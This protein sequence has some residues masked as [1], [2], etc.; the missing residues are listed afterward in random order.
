MFGDAFWL[1][2]LKLAD[3][4]NTGG[5]YTIKPNGAGSG[6]ELVEV[7]S[8]IPR[9]PAATR[10][11]SPVISISV[12]TMV[13]Q[14]ASGASGIGLDDIDIAEPSN[15]APTISSGNT[16]SVAENTAT[17]T[18]VYTASASDAEGDAITYSLS[19]TDAAAFSIDTA[20]AIRLLN[21]ADFET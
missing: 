6:Q 16:A 19:G 4:S 14:F 18:V 11:A 2:S 5:I 7:S 15:T 8:R 10:P 12:V 1:K 20:G 17:S 21:P 13:I 9:L 3:P